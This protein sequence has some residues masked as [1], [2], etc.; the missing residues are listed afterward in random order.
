MKSKIVAGLYKVTVKQGTYTIRNTGSNRW[1]ILNSS[2][3][4]ITSPFRTLAEAHAFLT[5]MN[6]T[7][8]SEKAKRYL[9]DLLNDK[10]GSPLAETIRDY[11]ND[12]RRQ[13]KLISA[14]DVSLA[15]KRLTGRSLPLPAQQR[16]E[17]S[18]MPR[19]EAIAMAR[20]A[21]VKA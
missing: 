15:I 12:Q 3:R 1:V 18:V 14:A 4:R 17:Q 2:N 11:F 6:V 9:R 8:A 16:A 13:G 10:A 5:G 21:L 19:A 20:A 7:P